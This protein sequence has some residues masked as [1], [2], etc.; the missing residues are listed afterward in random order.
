M[1]KIYSQYP[2]WWDKTITIYN[3]YEDPQTQVITW[4]RHVVNECFWQYTVNKLKINNTVFDTSSI[5]CRIPEDDEF[6]QKHLWVNLPNDEM[7]NFFTLGGGDIIVE[8]E[9]EDTIDEYALGHTASDLLNKYSKY[10]QCIEIGEIA[11]NIGTARNNPHYLVSD[12]SSR[13]WNY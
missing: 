9:V 4:Y 5:I 6:I 8:G 12:G 11:L 2:P 1:S 10:Q 7:E 13:A 3:K